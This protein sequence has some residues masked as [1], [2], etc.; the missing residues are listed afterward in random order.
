MSVAIFAD[1]Y[2]VSVQ[3]F[4]KHF[5]PQ[6]TKAPDRTSRKCEFISKRWCNVPF[7][8]RNILFILTYHKMLNQTNASRWPV[9]FT[10]PAV[11]EL[12]VQ[13]LVMVPPFRRW[14]KEEVTIPQG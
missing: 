9:R 10:L 3:R 11:G 13:F 2:E 6:F 7:V 8:K 4:L 1:Q 5:L 12:L 14:L